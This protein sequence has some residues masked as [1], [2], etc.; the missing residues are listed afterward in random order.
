M[1]TKKTVLNA[2][3]LQRLRAELQVS[4]LTALLKARRWAPGEIAFQGGTN[5]SLVH[6]SARFSEDLDF[7][8]S[9]ATELKDLALLV[10]RGLMMPASTPPGMLLKV[11]ASRDEKAP[12]ALDVVLSGPNVIGSARVKVELWRTPVDVLNQVEISVRLVGTADGSSTPVPSITLTQALADK[13]YALGARSRLKARDIYDTWWLLYG[14]PAPPDLV[15]EVLAARLAIYPVGQPGDVAQT[16]GQWMESAR[17]RLADLQHA[18]EH[19]Q[20]VINDLTRWLPTYWPLTKQAVVQMIDASAGR[21]QQGM[22]V[23]GEIAAPATLQGQKATAKP[24]EA[25]GPTP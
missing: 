14:S 19:P 4:A 12:Y 17:A 22:I 8:V 15:P 9:E 1:P 20:E 3:Q 2:D 23:I 16:A 13:V 6:G 7:M 10:K 11:S 25:P 21:L 24:D 5:L 18:A